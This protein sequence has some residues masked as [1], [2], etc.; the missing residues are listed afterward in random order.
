MKLHTLL[1]AARHHEASD[2]HLVVGLPPLLRID[3]SI[4]TLK[5]DAVTADRARAL[6]HELLNDAQKQRLEHDRA[7]CFST[8]FGEYD[9]ARV[10]VYFRDG[11]PE[12]S[13]RLSETAIR[14]REQLGLPAIVDD[15]A[16]R[17][18]GLIIITGPTGVGKTTTFHYM[19]DLIN[20]EF[21]KKI[22]TIEDP[23][24]YTHRFKRSVVV[25][26]EVLSDVHDFA[27]A[28][29]HVLRQDP[30]VIGIGEMRDRETM[31][32]ALVAAETGHLVIATLHTPGA[33]EV[34]QRITASFPEGQQE[35]VRFMLASTL[36]AVLAQQLLPRAVTDGRVLATEILVGTSGVLHMIR[37]NALHRV[38]SEMQAGRKHGMVTRDHTLL[39][40]YQRGDIAYD[41]AISLARY[42]EVIQQRSA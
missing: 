20:A 1:A 3:G 14:T 35:E 11:R 33:V 6:A 36:Q 29:R 23:I 38:Y 39:E 31:Y 17:P 22:V 24:E 2:L 42:P 16:R 10:A 37:E 32:T 34:V 28:L 13:I 40:L 21:R 26:Q 9:R 8:I 4:A 5:G 18:N 12:L 30:D 7:L 41:T 15:L 27:G 25:Q 19:I